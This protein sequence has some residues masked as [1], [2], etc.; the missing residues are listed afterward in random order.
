MSDFDLVI[1]GRIVGADDVVE[2]GWIATQDGK[3]CARGIGRPPGA[4]ERLDAR[5]QWV[6]PGVIDGQVHSGSQAR[7]EGLGRASRAAAAGGVT[8]MV[9]MPYDDPQP[10]ATATQLSAKARQVERECH[11]DVALYATISADAGLAE[12]PDLIARRAS[13]E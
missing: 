9:D 10:V 1:Q 11:V 2:N 5:N 3:I 8:V 4:S 7:Q 6:L 12:I 13:R